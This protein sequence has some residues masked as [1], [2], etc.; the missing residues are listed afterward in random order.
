MPTQ[1]AAPG[2]RVTTRLI[3]RLPDDEID[4]RQRSMT[5]P[6]L[7]EDLRAQWPDQLALQAE[8]QLTLMEL[9]RAGSYAEFRQ[10]AA[11]DD[12]AG[13]EVRVSTDESAGFG[14]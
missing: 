5:L 10:H 1:I 2:A 3:G 7:P 9:A 13:A 6:Q 14:G 4:G 8:F 11:S 12:P